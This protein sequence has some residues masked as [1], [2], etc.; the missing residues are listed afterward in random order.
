MSISVR[1]IGCKNEYT[2]TF[3]CACGHEQQVVTLGYKMERRQVKIKRQNPCLRCQVKELASP[4]IR[5]Q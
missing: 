3:H 5:R 4:N 1:K 2:E